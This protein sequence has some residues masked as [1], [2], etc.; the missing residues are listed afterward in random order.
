M[1]FSVRKAAVYLDLSVIRKNGCCG[2]YFLLREGEV[3]YVGKSRNVVCRV[4]QHIF[5]NTKEFNEVFYVP[6]VKEELDRFEAE[7]IRALEPKYNY[8]KNG[9]LVAA[10]CGA[11]HAMRVRERERGNIPNVAIPRMRGRRRNRRHGDG[12]VHCSGV[13]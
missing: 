2:V 13:R 7:M 5:E 12:Q 11:I 1:D 6:L 3:V 8:G 9:K 10:G 4:A